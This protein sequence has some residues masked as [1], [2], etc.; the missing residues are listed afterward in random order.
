MAEV[1]LR[2]N[3]ERKQFHIEELVKDFFGE[4]GF[5]NNHH[6]DVFDYL[7]YLDHTPLRIYVSEYD[8]QTVRFDG[9]SDINWGGSE[10]L[11]KRII[12]FYVP[13]GLYPAF[14]QDGSTLLMTLTTI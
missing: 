7:G 2:W 8:N 11:R 4:E 14:K 10:Y 6:K 5:L 9:T 1:N 13:K 12:M 3:V